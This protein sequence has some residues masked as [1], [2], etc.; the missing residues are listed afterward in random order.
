MGKTIL[1]IESDAAFAREMSSALEARGFGVRVSADGKEGLDVARDLRPDAVVLCVEL[2][3]MSGYSVCNKLKK[4]DSLR[5]IPLVIISA[6]ATQETFEQHR[7]LKTRAEDYLIKP[8][9]PETLVERVAA[10]VGLPAPTPGEE[11]MVTLADVELEQVVQDIPPLDLAAEDD[12]DLRLLDDAFDSIARVGEPLEAPAPEEAATEPAAVETPEDAPSQVEAAP[13]EAEE[14]HAPPP[15]VEEVHALES[16]AVASEDF[17]RPAERVQEPSPAALRPASAE[18][19]RAAGIPILGS[20]PAPEAGAFEGDE[21]V[22]AELEEQRRD[23]SEA[24]RSLE[25]REAEVRELREEISRLR[26][27]AE[28]AEH[29]NAARESELRATRARLEAVHG[30]VKKLEADL[31]ASRDEARRALE[32]ATTLEKDSATLRSRLEEVE[33][34]ASQRG[35][36]VAEALARAESLERALEESR[37]EVT[38][39][40]NE[41]EALRGEAERRTADLRR[42]LA[43]VESQTARHEERVVKAYQKIKNDEK[44]KEKTRKALAIALQLLDERLPVEGGS[45]PAGGPERPAS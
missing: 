22:R 14:V 11:E 10:L 39:T 34:V 23:L 15:H 7:K 33:Q 20:E 25:G 43:E 42:R 36:D 27:T 13:P 45:D 1:L 19:L 26:G 4:D 6:E 35:A 37:T 30:T 29:E 41:A 28:Q 18:L 21:Q 3:R 2:P 44:L 16:L 9:P 38:V 31:K 40:R 8:F 5:S 32:R 24:Q 12:A 17:L